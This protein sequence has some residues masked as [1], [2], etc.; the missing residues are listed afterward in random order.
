M[1]SVDRP[2]LVAA[3]R[4]EVTGA[5][6]AEPAEY[7]AVIEGSAGGMKDGDGRG[8]GAPVELSVANDLHVRKE[9]SVVGQ[10]ERTGHRPVN[11]S[12]LPVKR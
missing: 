11:R 9:A 4:N 8:T 10:E 7:L 5:R 2:C 3:V 6:L 12:K 1:V